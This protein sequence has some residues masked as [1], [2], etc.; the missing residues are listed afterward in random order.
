MIP[1]VSIQ[2]F[3]RSKKLS[4]ENLIDKNHLSSSLMYKMFKFHLLF[5]LC[6]PIILY[7]NDNNNNN[8]NSSKGNVGRIGLKLN[9]LSLIDLSCNELRRLQELLDGL[10][11][12]FFHPR[13]YERRTF[14][15]QWHN[16][17]KYIQ[18]K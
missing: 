2:F 7:K 17:Y 14:L 18:Y 16:V 9:I 1:I 15:H 4:G 5:P 13:G 12:K 11:G 3:L 8:M 10:Y 6:F